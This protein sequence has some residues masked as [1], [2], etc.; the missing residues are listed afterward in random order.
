MVTNDDD[1]ADQ[2]RLLRDHGRS[3]NGKV[4]CFGFN[5]R[6]DNLHAA[7]LN[8][9]LKT[10]DQDIARRRELAARYHSQLKDVSELILPPPSDTDLDHYDIFQNYEIEAERRDELRGYLK[11]QGVGTI[12]QWGGYT[13]HQF[14]KLGFDI[15]PPCTER[16][17]RRFMLLPMNTTLMDEDVDY[18]CEKIIEFCL[19]CRGRS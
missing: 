14:E 17:T 8:F 12:L 6:L 11:E 13:I 5:A 18:V 15:V 16:M 9:K 1:V 4:A 7:I 19:S 2:V 10:Y 3:P